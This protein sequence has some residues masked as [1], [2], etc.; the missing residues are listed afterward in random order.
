MKNKV[1]LI[2]RLTKDPEARYTPEG[3]CVCNFSLATSESWKDKSTG[4]KVEK[5]EYHRIVVWRKLAEICG[6]YLTKGKLIYVEGKLQT[7][8]WEQDG[9]TRYIT[10]VIIDDMLMM[11]DGKRKETGQQEGYQQSPPQQ[12]YQQPPPQPNVRDDDIPF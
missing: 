10:E 11:P 9:V 8:N 7:R 6:Q 2:G 4:E 3:T 1:I 12:G 5:T